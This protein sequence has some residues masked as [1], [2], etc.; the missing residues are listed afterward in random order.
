MSICDIISIKDGG[1]FMDNPIIEER[2]KIFVSSAMGAEKDLGSEEAFKWLNF[3]EAVRKELN[4]C[5]YIQAFTIEQ[6]TNE[7]DSTNY[8][9]YK[10]EDSD[11]VVLLIKNEFRFGTSLEY[12]QCCK[13]KKPL[14]VFFFSDEKANKEV[15]AL[16]KELQDKNFCTYR[17]MVD[18]EN[19]EK[20]IA[21]DVIQNVIVYYRYHHIIPVTQPIDIDGVPIETEFDNDS[22]IPTKTVLSQ[23]KTSYKSI[24][25]YIGLPHL[26]QNQSAVPLSSLHTI[27]EQVIKWVLNGERFLSP[28]VKSKLVNSVAIIYPNVEWYSKRL[29]A[30]NYFI[31]GDLVNAYLSEK[32]AL[33]LAEEAKIAAW[34]ITNI[35]IDLRNF[36]ILCP[37]EQIGLEDE[38]YQKRLDSLDSIVHVPVL[39]RY[40]ENTYEALLNEEIKRNT[41]SFGTTFFGSN[42]DEIISGVENYLFSSLLYGSYTHLVLT[43]KIFATIFYR[44]GKLFNSNELLYFA[45]KMYLF[46]GQYKD[47]IR[48]SN[49][50]WNNI[51]NIFIINAD[52]LWHQAYN[53]Q[54]KLRDTICIGVLYRTGLYLND[55][56]FTE[57][58][59]YLLKLS[60]HLPWNISDNY[61]D[62]II[63]IRGRLTNENTVRILTTIIDEHKYIAAN[64]I[65]RLIGCLDLKS[66]SHETLKTL[67]EVLKK[68]LQDMVSRNGDPQCIAALINEKPDVFSEL[69]TL[70]NNGL[71]GEQ[72]LIY[73]L[74]TNK[75]D[76]HAILQSEIKNARQQFEVNN[77]KGIYNEFDINSYNVISYVFENNPSPEIIKYVTENLF[78]LCIDVLNSN[79]YF[80][81]KDQCAECLCTTLGYY[82]KN[83]IEIPSAVA[84]CIER[85]SLDDSSDF[86]M[87]YR[88]NKGLWCRLI[89]LKILVGVFEKQV[90]IQWCFSYSKK[91]AKERRALVQCLK[92][93]LQYSVDVSSDVDA[94]IISIIFQCCEDQDIY[95]RTVACKCLWYILDSH[96]ARQAEEKINEMSMDPAP[97]I[98]STLLHIF[99][100]NNTIHKALINRITLQLVNDANYM[101]RKQAKEILETNLEM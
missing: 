49:L 66:V 32:E 44:T 80:V 89:T 79:C 31:Q 75:G 76:W 86:T 14:L 55:S 34:I 26:S 37:K 19:A 61:M 77:Q 83:D 74:N 3:R 64:H 36:Q 9:L 90:L 6:H 70:P 93:Y 67:C 51:S 60:K 63:N 100:G 45:I 23:F 53:L 101:I 62:C 10:V 57:A 16:R 72:K 28:E 29:D 42:L 88:S 24:Y 17:N 4:K 2:L 39:D 81:I 84:D 69:G 25:N 46:N 98:R 96:Y 18:F 40:L 59:L 38:K 82:H 35:L 48:L 58:E 30:I 20:S 41:A 5:P 52:E 54:E 56:S 21:N 11:I 95:I 92:T 27:G 87:T 91:D 97:A 15:F 8:M 43:R 68:N 1:G 71:S 73:D 50:E 12:N 99:K 94:L 85:V 22:Y 47:F 7:I 78:P 33:K 13:T 65:T